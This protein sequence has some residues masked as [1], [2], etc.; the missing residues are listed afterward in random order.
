M[1]FNSHVLDDVNSVSGQAKFTRPMNKACLPE[2]CLDKKTVD[3][4]DSNAMCYVTT[5]TS[6]DLF[7]LC[8]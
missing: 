3:F 4:R 8:S 2:V 6:D 7:S 1:E 5:D